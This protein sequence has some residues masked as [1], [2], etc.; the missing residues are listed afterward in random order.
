MALR[1]TVFRQ[2][3]GQVKRN[4]CGVRWGALRAVVDDSGERRDT[5]A[6]EEGT[7]SGSPT[8]KIG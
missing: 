5:R 6:Q 1:D 4:V 3:E 7:K 2:K 8:G